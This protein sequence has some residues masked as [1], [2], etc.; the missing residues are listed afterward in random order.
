MRKR[1]SKCANIPDGK[2]R[3]NISNFVDKDMVF[4]RNALQLGEIAQIKRNICALDANLLAG[5]VGGT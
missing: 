1:Y 2:K 5:K 4:G 3:L